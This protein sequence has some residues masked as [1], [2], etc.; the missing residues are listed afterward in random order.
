LLINS[1]V[2]G[3]FRCANAVKPDIRQQRWGWI[4]NI[5]GLSWRQSGNITGLRNASTVHL[6]KTFSDQ[7]SPAGITVNLV[8]PGATRTQRTGPSY[9]KRARWGR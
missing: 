6:T 4:I 8:Q 1:K 3:Y 2:L 5:G 9:A 7:L